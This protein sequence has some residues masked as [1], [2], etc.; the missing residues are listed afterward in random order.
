MAPPSRDTLS[1]L[2]KSLAQAQVS[3]ARRRSLDRVFA[4]ML[5]PLL[6]GRD[7]LLAEL[8]PSDEGT[9]EWRAVGEWRDGAAV[10][11]PAEGRVWVHE[12]LVRPLLQGGS[13]HLQ[14]D[15]AVVIDG[16]APVTE[17]RA[18]PLCVDGELIGLLV[19]TGELDAPT[20]GA[21][22]WLADAA[23]AMVD[24]PRTPR[25]A[26][27]ALRRR[28]R[29]LQQRVAQLARLDRDN[30]LLG[31]LGGFLQVCHDA[32][33]VHRVIARFLPQLFEGSSGAYFQ[34]SGRLLT[35]EVGW[36]ASEGRA[37]VTVDDCWALRR[38]EVHVAHGPGDLVCSHCHQAVRGTSVCVPVMTG[39]GP[40]GLLHVV[41]DRSHAATSP[42]GADRTLTA[43]ADR[44]GAALSNLR[45]R[46]RLRQESIRDPLTGL[47][48]RRYMVETLQ[49][50]LARARRAGDHLAVVMADVDHFKRLNDQFGHATG[51]EV[52]QGVA[53][54]L[55]RGVRSEDVV[56]RYGGEEFVVILP[57]TTLAMA[58]QRA[59]QLRQSVGALAVPTQDGDVGQVTLS[60]GVADR[61]DGDS[62][63]ALLR[64]ADR[65]LFD[66][67]RGG[68]DRVCVAREPSLPRGCAD[69]GMVA[70][71]A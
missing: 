32:T 18:V 22:P 51:D 61:D 3:F 10:A 58:R 56:C 31:D 71:S 33:D 41:H 19:V 70:I 17:A 16:H 9:A 59:E 48:N 12:A 64:A 1:P 15:D 13:G 2:V 67:K 4:A 24:A 65:A 45:L 14:H 55:Q 26:A 47:F 66:A 27:D 37:V 28:N 52:L 29:H 11:R 62:P 36:G 34:H 50:E 6:P 20:V 54:A 7:V 25:P 5:A 44:L 68:R 35:Q 46:E 23:A 69:P 49:R 8:V 39:D 63:E 30:R 53:R 38:G 21:L 40:V 60:A 57:G 43:V 42:D